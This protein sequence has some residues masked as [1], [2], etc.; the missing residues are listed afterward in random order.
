[1]SKQKPGRGPVGPEQTKLK[2][3]KNPKHI[4]ALLALPK[5]E[6]CEFFERGMT[7]E[8]LA[9]VDE[10]YVSDLVNLLLDLKKSTVKRLFETLGQVRKRSI[11]EI[12]TLYYYKEYLTNPV[13]MQ[14]ELQVGHHVPN[15][16]AILGVPRDADDEDLRTAYRM[17]VK[18]HSPEVFSP[19]IRKS[20]GDRLRDINEAFENLKTPQRRDRTDK[21]LPNM[22]YLYP[23][24]D[25]SWLEAVQR[26]VG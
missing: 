2:A 7:E 3:R 14:I 18:A 20:G 13:P 11:A 21:L 25:Q 6:C 16:Y 1:M 19:A 12:A 23:R 4:E 17:L 15:H 24:R 26:V 9:V 5:S 8:V 10:S 22:S